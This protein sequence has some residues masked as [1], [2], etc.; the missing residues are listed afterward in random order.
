[1]SNILIACDNEY[2]KKW[3]INFIK[4]LKKFAPWVNLNVVVVNPSSIT[5]L[6]NVRYFY[7]YVNFPNEEC[8][9]PYYQAVRF[10]KCYEL[11]PNNELVMTLDCDT[12]CTREFKEKDFTRLCREIRV[13]RHPNLEKSRLLAGLVTFG[14]DNKFRI[15][16][17][18]E[19]LSKPLEQ[20]EYGRD[21]RVLNSLKSEFDY[22]DLFADEWLSFGKN[23]GGVFLT[24]KGTQ[25]DNDKCLKF[26][27]K[28]IK[29]I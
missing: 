25:K 9:I 14:N 6:D 24:L 10:I 18:E 22:K 13:Q 29:D 1:M 5:E 15:K 17:R 2:Y 4:S 3:G 28:I 8:K 11:F 20:W 12:V 7:D 19:L 23:Q 26:Y 16:I 27:N 21:Q